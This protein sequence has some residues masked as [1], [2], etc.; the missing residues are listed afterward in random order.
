[1]L[2][3]NFWRGR[4]YRL[5]IVLAVLAAALFTAMYF[6]TAIPRLLYP[7]DLDFI[8]DGLVMTAIRLAEQQPVFVAPQSNFVPHVYMPLLPWLGSLLF[9][10]TGPSLPAL[11]LVSMLAAG[12]ICG[13]LYRVGRRESGQ[14]WVGVVCA[15]LFLAGYQINGFTYELARVDTLFVALTLAGLSLGAYHAGSR[16]GQIGAAAVLALAFFAKQTALI[17]GAGL[18]AYL[19]VATGRRAWLYAGLWGTLVAG[20]V[21]VLNARTGGWFL[22]YT[23]HIAGINPLEAGR[24]FNFVAR[25]L[26]GLMGGLSIMAGSAVILARRRAG[27]RGIWAQPWFVWLGL[28]VL[29]SGLGRASVGGNINNRMLAYTLLCLGPALLWREWLPQTRRRPAVRVGAITALILAQFALGAYNPWRYI[30]TAG[31]EQAGARLVNKIAAIDGEVLV[32]MH[33]YYAWLAGKTPSA[34]MAAM[35]HARERGTQPLPRDFVNR[36]EQQYYAAI[37]TDNSLFETEPEFKDLLTAC[38]RLAERLSPAESPPTMAGMRVK[39]DTL[40]R[41]A[42]TNGRCH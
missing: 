22:Y 23:Y 15:G 12:G 17:A 20:P 26:F 13:L 16:R 11:R 30:P 6:F 42:Q 10:L 25:E 21:L 37:I 18:G 5:C 28:A 3:T 40:Y 29:A 35:W 34:Q 1:M 24:V 19:L 39:P 31:M 4:L 9:G 2:T 32:L 27:C 38:Y 41:P 36:L 8:E 7:Y 14:G 33:P